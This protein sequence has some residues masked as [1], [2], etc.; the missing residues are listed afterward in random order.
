MCLETQHIYSHK[1]CSSI[2]NLIVCSYLS[3]MTTLPH[4]AETALHMQESSV[5]LIKAQTCL[6][7]SQVYLSSELA[8]EVLL[9]RFSGNKDKRRGLDLNQEEG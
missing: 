7:D 3:G 5:F 9:D 4:H 8:L 6:E 1:T 2:L